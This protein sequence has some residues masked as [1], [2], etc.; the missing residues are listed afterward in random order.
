MHTYYIS[1]KLWLKSM[2]FQSN[3]LHITLFFKKITL[4]H[5][6]EIIKKIFHKDQL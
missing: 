5:R 6:L 1:I 3:Q 4:E 2:F